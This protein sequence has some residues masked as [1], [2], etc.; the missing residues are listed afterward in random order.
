MEM[1]QDDAQTGTLYLTFIDSDV[2]VHVVLKSVL[3]Q[4]YV[5][6]SLKFYLFLLVCCPVKKQRQPTY[7]T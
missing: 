4:V 1:R 7:L 3:D 5:G 6:I 2:R